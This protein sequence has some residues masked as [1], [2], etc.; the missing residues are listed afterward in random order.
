MRSKILQ[1]FAMWHI[2]DDHLPAIYVQQFEQLDNLDQ[3]DIKT[4]TKCSYRSDKSQL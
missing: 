4:A 1:N 2:V 3:S